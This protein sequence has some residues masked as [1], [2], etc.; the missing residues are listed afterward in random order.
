MSK[1]TCVPLELV[2]LYS[3]NYTK[4]WEK[5]E[6]EK[7][8]NSNEESPTIKSIARIVMSKERKVLDKIDYMS[9]VAIDLEMLTAL[10]MWRKNKQIYSFY[11]ELE[12]LLYE[13]ATEDFNV[14]VDVLQN[15]PYSCIFIET[16]NLN[17]MD[18]LGFFAF[19]LVK[20][21][22][23]QFR[24]MLVTKDLLIPV[25]LYVAKGQNIKNVFSHFFDQYSSFTQKRHPCSEQ[26]YKN[27]AEQYIRLVTSVMQLLLYICAQNAEISEKNEDGKVYKKRAVIKDQ[28]K[29]VRQ[30]E[31]GRKI[32]EVIRKTVKVHA[33]DVAIPEPI[34]NRQ[35]IIVLQKNGS[36]KRPHVRKGH[37]HH[38]W[39]GSKKEQNRQLKLNWIAPSIIHQEM[40]DDSELPITI[41]QVVNNQENKKI[42]RDYHE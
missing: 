39:I 17:I 19:Y 33:N 28:Y 5:I 6:Y 24:L 15:L 36:Q 35:K 42:E 27:Q 13:Q 41:N 29:E 2:K 14:P 7:C 20:N 1:S 23:K 10:S 31:C 37:W 16:K 30:F 25:P 38:Y 32:S 22:K 34:N 4:C 8:L 21:N 11:G 26:D 18:I 40:L 3:K 9:S 12:K